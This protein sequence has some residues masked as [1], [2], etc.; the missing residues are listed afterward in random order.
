MVVDGEKEKLVTLGITPFKVKPPDPKKK[1]PTASPIDWTDLNFVASKQGA[2]DY[3][4]ILN[5]ATLRDPGTA[6]RMTDCVPLSMGIMGY[7]REQSPG[8]Y[9]KKCDDGLCTFIGIGEKI[10]DNQPTVG[11]TV[12]PSNDVDKTEKTFFLDAHQGF[13]PK[14]YS[15]RMGGKHFQGE[16]V[17]AYLLEA[18]RCSGDRWFPIHTVRL[19]FPDKSPVTVMDIRVTELDV[20]NRPSDV[21]FEITLPAGTS[22]ISERPESTAHFALKQQESLNPSDIPRMFKLLE[23]STRV[24]LMDTAVRKPGWTL[25]TYLYAIGTFIILLVGCFLF[26]RWRIH[27]SYRTKG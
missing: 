12:V 10:V 27:S 2:V 13:L 6:V 18:K 15:Y 5:T 14:Q 11:I 17:R 23:D 21:D 7:H 8:S 16:V 26:W 9:L 4:H 20:E 1:G 22:I 24:P 19:M 25:M 3:A